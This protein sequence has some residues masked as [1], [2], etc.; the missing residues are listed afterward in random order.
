MV[1]P[2]SRDLRFFG[3]SDDKEGG[4]HYWV[5]TL[6]LFLFVPIV[7]VIY[8]VFPSGTVIGNAKREKG[9]VV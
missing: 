3:F 5:L 9:E 4:A 6:L 7:F 1:I 8:E 2:C